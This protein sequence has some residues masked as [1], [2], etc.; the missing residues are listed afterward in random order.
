MTTKVQCHVMPYAD[1][2]L[3]INKHYMN[4]KIHITNDIEVAIGV[5]FIET[6]NITWPVLQ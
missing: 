5:I 4:G 6:S 3:Q 2:I 1:Y